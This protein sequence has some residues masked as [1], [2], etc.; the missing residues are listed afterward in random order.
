MTHGPLHHARRAALV[1]LLSAGLVACDRRPA[2][3]PEPRAGGADTHDA[4]DEHGHSDE[5]RLSAE[6]VER[7]G[8]RVEAAQLW[9]LRPTFPAPARVAFN[10]DAV[11]HVGSPLRGRAV[12]VRARVGDEVHRGDALVIVE[13][14]ELGEAQADYFQKR[15]AAEAAGPTVELTRAAWDR[16]KALYE[17]SQG[18]PLTEVHRRE[19]EYK[20]AAASQK[21]ALAAAIGAENRLHLLGMSQ[22][23]VGALARSGEIAP[24]YTLRA[25]LDG[26]VIER[27]VTLGELVS[28]DREALLV[29]ADTRTLWVLADVPESRAHEVAPG[30]RAWVTVPGG[31]K[32]EG[33]VAMI[34]PTADPG[35]R[36]AEVRVEVSTDGLALR[37]GMFARVEIVTSDPADPDPAPVVAVPEGAVQTVEGGPA[38]FVP[39]PGEPGAFA[40]RAVTV[41]PPTGGLIAVLSG[42][43][44]GERF[45]AS[46][47]FILKAELGKAGAAHEH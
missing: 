16:A 40:K 17:Q 18:I 20:A 43:V 19:A 22:D 42:L 28:P 21:M 5:V 36:T 29:L 34:A 15:T 41:D 27:E 47:S 37:P 32:V 30:A 44:E 35:T 9:A 23:E 4:H 45:V 38:V 12:E 11:A 8:V 13:S 10:S 3:Q 33:R 7:Y 1:L 2:P 46:G 39:V 31:R 14:P 24:R 26:K 25:P 6:A